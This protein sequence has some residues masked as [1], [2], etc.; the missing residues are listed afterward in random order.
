MVDKAEELEKKIKE[1]DRQI[2]VLRSKIKAMEH[3]V[4]RLE[5]VVWLI[6]EF[7][8]DFLKQD[9]EAIINKAVDE[10]GRLGKE[11]S[12]LEEEMSRIESKVV[13]GKRHR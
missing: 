13:G 6:D 3:I 4:N 11:A 5:E 12:A 9:V 10:L 1:L 2:T 7:K 8:L